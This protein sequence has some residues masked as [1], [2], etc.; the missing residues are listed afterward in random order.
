MV[1]FSNV[2][3]SL[4][5]EMIPLVLKKTSLLSVGTHLWTRSFTHIGLSIINM[6]MIFS[7]ISY[8]GLIKTDNVM[9]VSQLS[10][11][12]VV[13]MENNKFWFNTSKDMILCFLDLPREAKKWRSREFLL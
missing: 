10:G 13:C 4:R 6:P 2:N 8:H 1:G 7:Y 3:A 12:Y 5:E 9:A 11:C